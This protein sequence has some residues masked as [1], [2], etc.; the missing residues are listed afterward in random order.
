VTTVV[1]AASRRVA[2]H[3]FLAIDLR[4]DRDVLTDGKTENIVG[5]GQTKPIAS[6]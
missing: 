3:D 1:I 2:T 4:L 6:V 5:V